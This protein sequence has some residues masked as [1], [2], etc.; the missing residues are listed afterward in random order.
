MCRP[1]L[2]A[3]QHLPCMH[4]AQS[5]IVRWIHTP[6]CACAVCEPV[7][8]GGTTIHSYA[9]IGLGKESARALSEKIMA[10][11]LSSN[12]WCMTRVLMID[13]VS[14]LSGELLD[15][16]EYIAR[17]VRGKSAPFGAIQVVLCGAWATGVCVGEGEVFLGGGSAGGG[18]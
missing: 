15:K 5:R 16:L 2:G 13:E 17:V 18:S 14:M 8:I 12:R 9:G 6:V 1:G 4:V 11:R 7:A 10:S 3:N